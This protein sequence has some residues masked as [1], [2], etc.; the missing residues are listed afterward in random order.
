M[1]QIISEWAV[2]YFKVGGCFGFGLAALGQAIQKQSP[3]RL[4]YAL[5]VTF[6]WPFVFY[7]AWSLRNDR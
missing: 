6:M 4:S 7:R 1:L 2:V 3:W 5:L